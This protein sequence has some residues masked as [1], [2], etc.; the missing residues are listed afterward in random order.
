[1]HIELQLFI[2]YQI[3]LT[4]SITLVSIFLHA[5]GLRGNL[6]WIGLFPKLCF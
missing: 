5:R 4:K 6:T 2:L 1:M 3:S